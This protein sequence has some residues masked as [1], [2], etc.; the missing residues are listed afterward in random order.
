M[1]FISNSIQN[2]LNIN[3]NSSSQIAA[4]YALAQMGVCSKTIMFILMFL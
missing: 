3:M 4:G 2:K 1:N